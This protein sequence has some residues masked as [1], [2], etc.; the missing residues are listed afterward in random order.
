ML[1]NIAIYLLLGLLLTYGVGLLF[2]TVLQDFFIFRPEKLAKDFQFTFERPF[3]DV[4]LE[5]KKQ[6]RI[7]GV[8]FRQEEGKKRKG[9]ILYFHGN[10][11]SLKR[12][13]HLYHFFFRFGY[14]F[15]T[16]DYRGYGKSK[17]KRT[18]RLM[19]DDA[20]LA[21][22]FIRQHYQPEEIILFGRSLG[23]SFAS[24]LSAEVEARLV[25]LETPFASMVDLFYGYFPIF[26]KIFL[27]KYR[28]L[29]FQYLAKTSLP[30][31][32]FH[33]TSD[34]VVPYSVAAK[35]KPVLKA[36]DQF[37]TVESG[38]HNNLLFFDLYNLEMK[39]ILG[40][41]DR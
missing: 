36:A 38:G 16:I 22:D 24:R 19:Y 26:P 17:G 4:W 6:G 7:N 12:W 2:T 27:F 39:K 29:N 41:V 35:L 18:E 5:G 10:R 31:Y 14:D 32:I 33:G 8:W 37:Y 21:Y 15:F 25:I 1:I 28:F 3:Q 13:G 20:Q 11:G 30:V 9:V 23:A 34:L 40:Q